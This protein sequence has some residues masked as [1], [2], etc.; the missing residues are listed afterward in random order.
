MIC[1][2]VLYSAGTTTHFQPTTSTATGPGS[3]TGEEKAILLISDLSY[4]SALIH[5]R[6]CVRR[7]WLVLC[8]EIAVPTESGRLDRGGAGGLVDGTWPV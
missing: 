1:V 2:S 5:Q 3:W 8:S 4:F 6:S 7:A